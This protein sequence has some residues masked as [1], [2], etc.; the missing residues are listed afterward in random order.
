M[1]GC[2]FFPA[3]T[4][5]RGIRPPNPPVAGEKFSKTM[6]GKGTSLFLAVLVA[7]GS[8]LQPGRAA[9]YSDGPPGEMNRLSGAVVIE[10]IAPDPRGGKAYRLRYTVDVTLETYWRFKTDFDNQFLLENRYIEEHRLVASPGDAVITEN[11]YTYAPGA[12]FRWKTTVH[13]DEKTIDFVLLNPEECGQRFH[14]GRIRA[15]ET[16]NKTL[17]IQKAFFDFFGAG[18]WAHYPWEGGMQHFLHYTARWEQDTAK[19]LRERYR[20]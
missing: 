9:P 7:A 16:G 3:R 18:M 11:R 4:G 20:K 14:Y 12:V 6:N 13:E 1:T 17:V 5:A 10:T 8:I 15:V 2:R 19:K